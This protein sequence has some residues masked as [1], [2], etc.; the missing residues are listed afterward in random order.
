M[1]VTVSVAPSLTYP[2]MQGIYDVIGRRT[3]VVVSS[4]RGSARG[5]V[6]IATLT[7]DERADVLAILATGYPVLLQAPAEFGGQLYAA[8]AVVA[9]HRPS[10]LGYQAPRLFELQLTEVDAPTIPVT[11]TLFT[12]QS[13]LDVYATYQDVL[14]GETSYYDLLTGPG[15]APAGV[16]QAASVERESPPRLPGWLDVEPPLTPAM[17]GSR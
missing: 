14:I 16:P 10:S 15:I 3:P 9:E 4:V 2:I 5:Q 17:R 8:V 13:V 1:M 6:T 11:L 7:L 12:Y